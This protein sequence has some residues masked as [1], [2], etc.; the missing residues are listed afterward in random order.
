MSLYRSSN[1]FADNHS[2]GRVLSFS[3]VV[4]IGTLANPYPHA[5]VSP[6]WFR[7]E[8]AHSLE[9]ERV[10]ESQFRRGYIRCG[11]LYICV[12]CADN[13]IDRTTPN[14]ATK[15]LEHLMP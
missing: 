14:D 10:G 9:R 7:G 13:D 4:G 2:V 8:G 5:S 15:F 1:L 12:L 6:L 3:P 11:T